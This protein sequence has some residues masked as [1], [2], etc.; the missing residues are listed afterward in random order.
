MGASASC[1]PIAACVILS[2][3]PL[4]QATVS[5]CL[6]CA[7]T[8]SSNTAAADAC[9]TG[10]AAKVLKHA[11]RAGKNHGC[12]VL[13]HTAN[14]QTTWT[15]ACCSESVCKDNVH[16][17]LAGIEFFTDSCLTDNCNTMDLTSGSGFVGMFASNLLLLLF[18]STT[19]FSLIA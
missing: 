16:T 4:S 3:V 8:S 15:R 7:A 6:T 18:G 2:L 12:S 10:D 17:N 13:K 11:C 1:L 19:L 14:G 5:E 9:R